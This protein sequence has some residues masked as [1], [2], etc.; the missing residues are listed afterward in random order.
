MKKRKWLKKGLA[1]A[2]SAAM[3]LGMVPGNVGRTVYAEES[4]AEQSEENWVQVGDFSI[5]TEGVAGIDYEYDATHVCLN[6]LSATSITIKNTDP[7]TATK[8]HIAVKEGISADITLAGVNIDINTQRTASAFAIADNSAGN[9]TVHL[10]G[11]NYLTG[12]AG[13][14]GLQKNGSAGVGTLT[15]TGN[16]ELTAIGGI[17]AA[18]IGGGEEQSACNIKINSGT[19]TAT[20]GGGGGAGIGGGYNGTGSNIT[21]E[22]GSVKA[23]LGAWGSEDSNA[24]GGGGGQPAATPTN[25]TDPVYLLEIENP[26]AAEIQVNGESYTPISHGDEKKIY[27]YLPAGKKDRPNMVTVGDTTKAYWYDAKSA[28]WDDTLLV[29]A[30]PAAD[31]TIYTYDG[32]DKIYRIAQG[33]LYTV[34]GNVQKYAGEYIVTVSLKNKEYIV[35]S[36]GSNEDRKYRFTIGQGTLNTASIKKNIELSCDKTT[37]KVSEVTPPEN[38][39]WDEADQSKVLEAGSEVDV[40]AVYNG[41]DKE[42]YTEESR[43]VTIRITKKAHTDADKDGRCD[44]EGCGTYIDGLGAKLAGYSLSL[45]GNIG[46]NFYM[47]LSDAVAADEDAYM[48]FKLPNG[49]TSKVYVTGT[50]ADGV[51]AKKDSVTVDGESKEYYVFPCEVAA[52]EMTADIKAQMVAEEEKGTEYT[53]TVKDYA[54]YIREHADQYADQ[55]GNTTLYLVNC[56]LNYGGY[57]QEYFDY[58]TDDLANRGLTDD[59][60]DLVKNFI[61]VRDFSGYEAEV[62]NAAEVGTF[63]SAYL[64]LKSR[65]DLCVYV[66]LA[67][68]VDPFEVTFAVDDQTV[69]PDKLVVENVNGSDCYKLTVPNIAANQL[70]QMHTFTVTRGSGE[71]AQ[72]STLQYGAF[73]YAYTALSSEAASV[74]KQEELC[75]ALKAMYEYYSAAN[76]YFYLLNQ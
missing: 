54:D 14:A 24:I 31:E 59:Y 6:I 75:N 12:S 25:G 13:C 23:M 46:V 29:V 47:E 53:Y 20:G 62:D 28:Q 45:A 33:E 26:N 2:L 72:R 9:V 30:V 34:T 43:K 8:H 27:A 16:G 76:N 39:N 10:V 48:N 56:M 35:W 3:V 42:N 40:T 11:E 21:I 7:S 57:A 4:E 58:R 66:K 65:T 19:I 5:L 64:S 51:T 68:G 15:I 67:D 69:S 1:F 61:N 70:D 44:V 63:V 50:H 41:S 55:Y 32:E 37:S 17:F 22:G 74:A 36:D 73:S 60:R 71:N 18:G 52:K 49:T 38:W